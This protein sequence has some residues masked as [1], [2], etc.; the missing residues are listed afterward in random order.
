MLWPLDGRLVCAEFWPERLMLPM[1]ESTNSR[2]MQAIAQRQQDTPLLDLQRYET[3]LQLSDV[4]VS[5]LELPELFMNW[6]CSF[7]EW[8]IAQSSVL[9][10]TT[11]KKI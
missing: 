11:P 8:R 1:E 4:M 3:L 9:F 5:R 6:R 2:R 7:K 10:C